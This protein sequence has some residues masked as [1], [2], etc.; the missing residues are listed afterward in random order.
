MKKHLSVA[1]LYAKLTLLPLFLIL[2][3]M[4]AV[5]LGGFYLFGFDGAES[6]GQNGG[7]RFLLL[8]F[9]AGFLALTV[10][11]I[12]PASGEGTGYTLM[13]LQISEKAAFF[14]H[15]AVA[16][17]SYLALWAAEAVIL[18]LLAK[19]FAAG[20]A[21]A[22]GPQ[23]IFLDFYRRDFFHAILPLDAVILWVRNGIFIL[24]AA[25]S[26]AYS[27]LMLR[28]R[29]KFFLPIL[30]FAL[31]A[32][33]FTPSLGAVSANAAISSII[34]LSLDGLTLWRALTTAHD[35]KG[36]PDDEEAF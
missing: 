11:L 20:E 21:Y 22:E 36:A 29:K 14:W 25:L 17:F 16:A 28:R 6:F 30:T 7:E 31:L 19:G 1:A 32:G 27:P 18:L 35:G 15:A 26:A 10:F 23:G 5:E 24:S 4:A 13:R 2:I 3:L 9:F 8:C 33:L 34:F 12:R